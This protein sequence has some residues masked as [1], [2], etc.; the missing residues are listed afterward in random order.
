MGFLMEDGKVIATIRRDYGERTLDEETLSLDPLVQ[1]KSWFDD[2]LASDKEADPTA[3]VV[4]TV[5]ASGLPDSRVLLLKGIESGRFVFYT[6]YESTK[7]VELAQNPHVALNFYWPSVARQV[8]VK[9]RVEPVSVAQSE[10]YFASRPRAS[11]LS[12]LSSP[13]SQEI[14]NRQYLEELVNTFTTKYNQQKVPCPKNWGG[15]W[16][17]PEEIEFWQGRDNRLHDRIQYF[18]QFSQWKFRRLAP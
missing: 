2:V 14:P 13:Q 10:A 6:N 9:G 16:V 5:D 17:E 11:Q 15:Y 3:M 4:S 8:R 12:A 1:F 18:K 7:G